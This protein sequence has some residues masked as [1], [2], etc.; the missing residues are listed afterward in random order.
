MSHTQHPSRLRHSRTFAFRRAARALS[1]TFALI[2]NLY[3]CSDENAFSA[4][5]AFVRL[6]RIVPLMGIVCLMRMSVEAWV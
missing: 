5:D 2:Q 1:V 3:S 4:L 6:M